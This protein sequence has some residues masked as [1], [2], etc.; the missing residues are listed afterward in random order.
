MVSAHRVSRWQAVD[1]R[2]GGAIVYLPT[3]YCSVSSEACGWTARRIA[4]WTNLQTNDIK[5]IDSGDQR[6]MMAEVLDQHA[7]PA[8]PVDLDE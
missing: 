3:A 6:G 7:S 2:E 1:E 4:D 8:Y 5:Y